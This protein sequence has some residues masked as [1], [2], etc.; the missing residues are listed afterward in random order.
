MQLTDEK[1]W[2]E[3]WKNCKLPSIVDMNFSFDRC[4]AKTIKKVLSDIKG[5]ALEV[6]CAPGRWL[7][8]LYKELGLIP[9]GIEYSKAGIEVTIK[10]LNLLNVKYDKIYNG[11]FFSLKPSSSFDV[12]ISLGFIEHFSNPDEVIE[13]HLRWLKP[14]GT[15]VLGVPNFNGINFLLQKIFDEEILKA[16]NLNIMST[17]YFKNIA[18]RYDLRIRFL[19]YIGSFEPSLIIVKP[20]RRNI[21]QYTALA[22][23]KMAFISRKFH[24]WDSI[25]DRQ[26][27]SYILAIY[28]RGGI[29]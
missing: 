20:G 27:S 15:L 5:T 9:S 14:S 29:S 23:L 10:N 11:D 13:S 6:G 12:V 22:F 8:F 1:Y 16:H 24:F 3:Y 17:E 2:D 25:N 28:K 18:S 26:L 7:A 21:E 19:D 4:L